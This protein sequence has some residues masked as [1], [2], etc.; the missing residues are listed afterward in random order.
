MTHKTL[1]EIP[2]IKICSLISFTLAHSLTPLEN[3]F[4]TLLCLFFMFSQKEPF[5]PI[6]VYF[7][8]DYTGNKTISFSMKIDEAG[9]FILCIFGITK[10]EKE[11]R[12]DA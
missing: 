9:D 1:S 6:E 4:L 7:T 5:L 8:K 2:Q 11:D 12:E 10:N 3:F